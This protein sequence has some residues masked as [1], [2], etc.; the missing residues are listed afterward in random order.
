MMEMTVREMMEILSTMDE[1]AYVDVIMQDVRMK[2]DLESCDALNTVTL[3]VSH[4]TKE[5]IESRLHEELIVDAYG[6]L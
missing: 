1:S 6:R 4:D 2:Y 3:R 5:L